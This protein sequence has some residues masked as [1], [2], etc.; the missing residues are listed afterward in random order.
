[1]KDSYL[2]FIPKCPV[3]NI[4]MILDDVDYNF[5]GN[6]DEYWTCPNVDICGIGLFVKIRFGKLVFSEVNKSDIN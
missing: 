1:M 4:E 5:E 6:Q 3:C 2:K